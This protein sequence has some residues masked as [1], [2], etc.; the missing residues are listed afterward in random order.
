MRR[1]VFLETVAGVPGMVAGMLRHMRSLRALRRDHGWIRT[2]LEE[3]RR[4]QQGT[5][6]GNGDRAAPAPL[7][8]APA[9]PAL[10]PD[11]PQPRSACRRGLPPPCSAPGR[12]GREREDAP[13]DVFVAAPAGAALQ[14]RRTGV[15]RV[16]RQGRNRGPCLLAPQLKSASR[17]RGLPASH[18]RGL[19]DR[20]R[21]RASWDPREARASVAHRRC[22]S[23]FFNVYFLL[24]LA[25]PRTAHAV[26][27]YLEE[28]AVKT[29]SHALRQDAGR[30]GAG[31]GRAGRAG[32]TLVA[33]ASRSV[34]C[35]CGLAVKRAG[36]VAP[37]AG[38]RFFES[39]TKTGRLHRSC[40]DMEA[41]PLQKW[42][43]TPAP[44]VATKYWQLQ[45]GATMREVVLA[46]RA[47][48][49]RRRHAWALQLRPPGPKSLPAQCAGAST[50]PLLVVADPER[51]PLQAAHAFV[52]HT[53]ADLP[54]SAKNPFSMGG[55]HVPEFMQ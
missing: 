22:R 51:A 37:P 29:Y 13:A 43:Q 28:E 45:P 50:I 46:I 11:L 21:Q 23:M 38:R 9:V 1:F 6:P 26:V 36:W 17:E 47:D 33:L 27:G 3:V 10:R 49:V 15:T 48:E 12:A 2:L 30:G 40:R 24:Y 52:N 55:H 5:S 31:W 7:G 16:R 35:P 20:R 54:Q 34:A 14:D 19:R 18:C 32:A 39:Q 53:F 41:G 25:S 44:E 42:A 4:G 8:L